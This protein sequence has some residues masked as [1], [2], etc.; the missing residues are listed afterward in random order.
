MKTYALCVSTLLAALLIAVEAKAGDPETGGFVEWEWWGELDDITNPDAPFTRFTYDPDWYVQADSLWLRRGDSERVTFLVDDFG[1]FFDRV[2]LLTTDDLEFQDQAGPRVTVGKQ[3]HLGTYIEGTYFTH[4]FS[5]SATVN[6]FDNLTV[7]FKP[8]APPG[9]PLVGSTDSLDEADR[10]V[11]SYDSELH[12]VELNLRQWCG[13]NVCFLAGA[14]YVNVEENFKIR[15]FDGLTNIF[16]EFPDTFGEYRIDTRNELLGGQ[17]G[18]DV[19]L[20]RLFG[21]QLIINAG[22]KAGA[23]ANSADASQFVGDVS[24]TVVLRNSEDDANDV[25]FLGEVS[26][27]ATVRFTDNIALRGGYFGMWLSGVALA[28]DQANFA[29][30]AAGSPSIDTNATVYYDGGFIGLEVRR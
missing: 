7:P 14:R 26:L 24:N 30:A 28:P 5:E 22:G 11:A 10:A 23:Y 4:D 3:I 16:A 2:E 13:D 9:L 21:N 25:A 6:G 15:T 19:V 17:L 27:T 18:A 20:L 29:P 8:F 12:N 1:F